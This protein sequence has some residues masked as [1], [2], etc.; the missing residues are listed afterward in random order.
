MKVPA[1]LR[2]IAGVR[3]DVSAEN[4]AFARAPLQDW[5]QV[6]HE[7]V[8]WFYTHA[9]PYFMPVAPRL[10]RSVRMS[11]STHAVHPEPTTGDAAK[12]EVLTRAMKEHAAVLGLSA[13]AV[14]EYDP[15]YA[16]EPYLGEN[17]G[18]RVV[19]CVLEQNWQATQEIPSAKAEKAALHAYAEVISRA[20]KLA[21]FLHERGYR[22]RA[23]DVQGENVVLH[24]AV[25]SGLGQLGLNGQVLTP[26]AGS[27]C[28]FVTIDTDAPLLV[29]Q[30]VD[31]GIPKICDA[32]QICVRR[33]PSG[34][35]PSQRAFYRGVEKAKLNAGRCFPVVARA[36]GCGICMK[37]CPV[38]RYGLEAV[39]R[40]YVSTGRVLGKDTDDLEGYEFEGS[41]YG[42][43]RRP[44]LLKE[45]F[46]PPGLV[47]DPKRKLP[48]IPSGKDLR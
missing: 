8:T 1:T 14:A 42:P 36:H 2:T 37:V 46:S 38:Q 15:R 24:Y 25:A 30:P 34:A 4:E 32:C 5:T 20:A 18:D 27:R 35:I 44:R 23:H 33:C 9:W 28:R 13:V 31:Y 6:H 26:F 21:A 19:V 45:W 11:N 22:A 3:R 39:T 17:C 29:D 47:F 40:E 43:G 12:P 16:F 48:L 10:V 41:H 7:A